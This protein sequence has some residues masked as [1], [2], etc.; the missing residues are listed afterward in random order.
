MPPRYRAA[1]VLDPLVLRSSSVGA[2]P[3]YLLILSL[4]IAGAAWSATLARHV[5]ASGDYRVYLPRIFAPEATS[6]PAH[7]AI[8]RINVYR[9]LAGVQVVQPHP[10]LTAAV[11]NHAHYD[12]QNY[13]DPAAWIYGPHGEVAGKPGFTG[14]MPG[15]RATA[16][17]YPW[18]TGWEVMDSFDDPT[19][20]IDALMATV[21]RLS[22]SRRRSL[23]SIV[24]C[25][26]NS[27][28][29]ERGP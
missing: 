15:D 13:A 14:Q 22:L 11:Q 29:A 28:E 7:I 19:R 1:M 25:R 12:L 27:N 6:D 20:S 9:T 23:K 26:H 24:R 3:R 10:A 17:G 18:A 4:L 21:R 8:E 5:T 16:A 2:D